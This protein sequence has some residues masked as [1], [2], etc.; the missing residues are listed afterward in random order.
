MMEF[1]RKMQNSWISKSILIL[2]ALS[3]VSLF[4]VS[5]YIGSAGKNKPVIKVGD[6]TVTQGE[7]S[8]QYEQELQLAKSLFGENMEIN[9]NIRNAMLQGIVQKELTNTIIKKVAEDYNIH[10]SDDLVRKIIFSQADFMD[11]NGNFNK[12]KFKRVLSASG[13]NE[14]RYINALR[15]DLTKQILVQ[16]PIDNINVPKVLENNLAKVAK[17]KKVF[18]YIKINPEQL[19][20]DRKMSQEELEQY[21]QDFNAQFIEGETRDVD[22]IVLS[23]ADIAAKI[24][25]DE[26]EIETY[27]Q[28]NIN[29]F[30]T[31]ETRD[32]M[33]MVFA[34]QEDANKAVAE[35][36]TGKDFYGVAKELAK[37]DEKTTDLGYVS[38]DMLIADMS[39]EVFSI[40]KGEVAGPVKSEMGWHIMKVANIKNGSKTSLEAAK[41]QIVEAIKKEKA[42]DEA[43]N[44][45]SNIEDQ[46]GSGQ[47]LEDIAKQMKVSVLKVKGLSEDGKAQVLP[48]TYDNII[49]SN[50]FVDTAFSYNTNELSQVIETDEGFLVLKV[51]KV[52]EAHPKD[53]QVVKSDIEQLWAINERNAI[54]QEI[55][56]DVMH[57]VE[58]GDKIDEIAARFQLNINTTKALKRNESFEGIAPQLMAELFQEP[59]DSAKLLDNDGIKI[60]AVNTQV[61]NDN[62][63][64]PDDIETVKRSTRLDLTNDFANQLVDNYGSDY[65]VRVKYRLLGL[66]D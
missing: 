14:Q 35:L 22:F 17:Q 47:S 54:S 2:T 26:E 27:Y 34:N 42:Y 52:V 59:I 19:K 1:F 15:L 44:I 3:F 10:I 66:S 11:T 51:V 7:I 60:I 28:E 25:P 49:K 18:K 40:S 50:E 41:K 29:Q 13:W 9:D 55:I 56:N 24:N 4:G 23:P 53:I 5:G 37:Q 38:K 62:H 12:D 6:F 32:I 20:I 48:N 33:Q 31:P 36:K 21:Y 30:E 45:S 16:N 63:I 39:D 8:G 64:T 61:I 46:I 57:D 65:D 58:T 43:Y